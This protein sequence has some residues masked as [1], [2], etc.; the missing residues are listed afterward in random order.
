[1]SAKK[2]EAEGYGATV[3]LSDASPQ[4]RSRLATQVQKATGATLIPPADHRDIVLGQ[5][6]A[7]HEFK[8][9]MAALRRGALDAIIVPSGGGGLLIGAAAACKDT[10][11]TVFGAEPAFGG[12]GLSAARARGVRATE[13]SS[14]QTVADGLR[15]LTGEANWEILRSRGNV[16]EVCAVGEDQIKDALTLAVQELRCVIEPSAAVGFAVALFSEGFKRWVRKV[17]SQVQ[18]SGWES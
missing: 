10:G 15:T 17:G 9:Q 12:P 3:I 5:A 6:T 1:M 4:E 7:I 18:Q 11:I 16:Q 2:I 14:G 13:L 8:Q